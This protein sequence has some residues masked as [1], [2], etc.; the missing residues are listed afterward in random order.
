[1]STERTNRLEKLIFEY[2]VP[3]RGAE[4]QWPSPPPASSTADLPGAQLPHAPI[5]A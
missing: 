1:M 2:S 3:G 5:A 4:D